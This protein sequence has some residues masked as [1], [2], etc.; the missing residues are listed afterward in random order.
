MP[1]AERKSAMDAKKERESV[2]KRVWDVDEE[3]ICSNV[4]TLKS[5]RS[6]SMPFN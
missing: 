5:A 3:T 4:E 6:G 2:G 1:M